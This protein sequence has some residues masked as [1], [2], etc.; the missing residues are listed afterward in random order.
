MLLETSGN[1]HYIFATNKLR[2][3]FGAS[4]LTRNAGEGWVLEAVKDIA[5]S[6]LSGLAPEATIED[7]RQT[8]L[9]QKASIFGDDPPPLEV[10]V[11]ASGKAILITQNEAAAKQIIEKLTIKALKEA[12]GL[13]L[14]GAILEIDHDRLSNLKKVA[15][16]D[17]FSK[18][19]NVLLRQVH[20]RHAF[21]H[22]K[23]PG[24]ETRFLRL[25][26]VDICKTS[27]MPA[28][29]LKKSSGEDTWQARSAVSL[30]KEDARETARSRLDRLLEHESIES[31]GWTFP[32]DSQQL[33]RTLSNSDGENTWLAVIHADGN[34]LGQIFLDFA[35]ILLSR[36]NIF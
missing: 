7:Q 35:H 31:H 30:A 13:D 10:I 12:P 6:P 19:F 27:G 15:E 29:T 34:G 5:M 2:E 28:K 9:N 14:C 21:V 24:N 18:D 11:A 25:P 17:K 26:I 22:A 32:K 4:E 20:E 3:N 1:Q 16:T 33:E 23:R 36:K 8:L